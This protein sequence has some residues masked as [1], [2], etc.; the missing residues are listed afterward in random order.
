VY[1]RF[2]FMSD[3]QKGLVEALKDVF[4]LNHSCY[5]A[6]HIARNVEAKYG[7]KAAKYVV[8]LAKTFSLSYAE[9]LMNAM[10]PAAKA[11]VG[12]IEE[13]QWRSTAWLNDEALPPRYGIVS[14]NVSE[15]ANSMFEMAR[16]V[17][18]KSSIHMILCKMVERIA[19]L[20]V[21]KAQ[22]RGVVEL[23]LK[24]LK[25]RW[26]NTA[27]FRIIPLEDGN[28]HVFTV[29]EPPNFLFRDIRGYNMN[30]TNK[31]CDCGK[32]QDNGFPCIHG[33]AYLKNYVGCSFDEVLEEV[34]PEHTYENEKLLFRRNFLTVCMDKVVSDGKTLPPVCHKRKAGR[35]K[36]QRHRKRSRYNEEGGTILVTCS[37]C[38]DVGHNVRTCQARES[39]ADNRGI[40][41]LDFL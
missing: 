4:P 35:P 16:D 32:W 39:M 13:A 25:D 40:P 9:E 6:V 22:K 24:K 8:E 19:T 12:D 41:E 18:W 15:S 31:A 7:K 5:C 21:A 20:R 27:G 26:E 29:F 17:S 34:A 30:V 28:E 37:R 14:S 2:T 36:K 1:K 10:G 3:R 33:V 23:V 11:Y 38:G